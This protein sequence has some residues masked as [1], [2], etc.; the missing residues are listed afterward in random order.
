MGKSIGF[1][2][3]KSHAPTDDEI[4]KNADLQDVRR[5]IDE[6]LLLEYACVY[7][8]CQQNAVV[9]AVSKGVRI[10]DDFILNERVS[11]GDS[12][13]A[14]EYECSFEARHDLRRPSWS[15]GRRH[16]LRIP[17]SVAAIEFAHPQMNLGSY[18]TSCFFRK[19]RNSSW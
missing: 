17:Q 14:Q 11:C 12:W 16:R 9:E 8:P 5:I 1:L 6:W 10:P 3:T 15:A 2:P 4:K 19:L 7:I 18:S 13:V